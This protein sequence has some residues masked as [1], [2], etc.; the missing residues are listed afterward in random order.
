MGNDGSRVIEVEKIEDKLAEC[1]LIQKK[2][3]YNFS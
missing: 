3:T 2:G 1:K